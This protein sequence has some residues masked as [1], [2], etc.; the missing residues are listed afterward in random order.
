MHALDAYISENMDLPT[1]FCYI[2]K[3]FMPY[4][5]N[6]KMDEFW[7]IKFAPNNHIPIFHATEGIKSVTVDDL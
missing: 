2:Y 7:L 1:F 5:A 6:N 3:R 4:Q